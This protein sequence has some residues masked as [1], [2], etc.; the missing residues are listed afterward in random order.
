MKNHTN[1]TGFGIF[2]MIILL[3][4]ALLPNGNDQK[5]LQGIETTT[6]QGVTD[7]TPAI[8]LTSTLAGLNPF[9]QNLKIAFVGTGWA[10]AG[11]GTEIFLMHTDGTGI[12]PISL[13]R[14]TDT[15]PVWSPDG[16]RIL[17]SS[18]RDGNYEIYSMDAD[19][20]NQ[21]R[22]TNDP[23]NDYDPSQAVDGRIVFSSNRDGNSEIYIMNETGGE[24]QKLF[25]RDSEDRYPV[26]SPDGKKIA[27]SSFGGSGESGIY[28]LD[29]D[30]N[31]IAMLAGPF[32]NP[33]WS[34][35]GNF[36]AM[37]GEPAGCKFEVYVMKADGTD[38][39]AVTSNPAGCG[40][41][42]KHPS[43]SP[44]GD[45]LVYSSQNEKNETN[46]FKIKVD[47]TQETQ[48]SDYK[49]LPGF[50]SHPHDPVWSPLP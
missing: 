2:F 21:V 35:D 41:Y 16:Q 49:A 48:L 29:L 1:F 9:D 13:Q 7:E 24:V 46:L 33:A 20:Q 28:I 30:G 10:V 11:A 42:N 38:V 44:D 39:H 47:G 50:L 45:W 6:F 17:F 15:D 26:W 3:S 5:T 43:W 14:E 31:Q 22:L 18:N 27:F 36:L 19:G 40:S 25:E 23:G 32:H 34:P 37:D 4:C 12:V 8:Q